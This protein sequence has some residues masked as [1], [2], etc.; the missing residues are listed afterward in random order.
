MKINVDGQWNED[1][2]IRADRVAVG[3]ARDAATGYNVAVMALMSVPVVE[4]EPLQVS[5]VLSADQALTFANALVSTA[6]DLGGAECLDDT[7][8]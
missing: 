4:G 8:S 2:T 5:V 1:D 6:L 3:L 7:V